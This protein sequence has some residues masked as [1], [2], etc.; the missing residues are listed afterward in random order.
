VAIENFIEPNFR[1]LIGY[2]LLMRWGC[3]MYFRGSERK[4]LPV[5]ALQGN[6][7]TAG[8]ADDQGPTDRNERFGKRLVWLVMLMPLVV[9]LLLPWALGDPIEV[10]DTVRWL[11]IVPAVGAVILFIWS[12]HVDS[13]FAE[14]LTFAEQL[15][16]R[17]KVPP[18]R[19]ARHPVELSDA[20]LFFALA[21]ISGRSIVGICALGAILLQQVIVIPLQDAELKRIL[22]T[23]YDNYAKSGGRFLPK[24]PMLKEARY[25]VPKRFG[26]TA[27]MALLTA[28]SLVFGGLNLLQYFIGVP[29]EFYFFAA[30]QIL[31]VCVAQMVFGSAP[32]MVSAFVGAALLP[33]FL[34]IHLAISDAKLHRYAFS[35]ILILSTF[36]G[37]LIG[38]C[39][40]AV[41]AGFFLFADWFENWFSKSK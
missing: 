30:A 29:R 14:P 10:P 32:R 11:F 5:V 37:G 40:G 41:A 38:Y 2:L 35:M 16:E 17:S 1:I 19:I 24:L 22:G 7:A 36:L 4:L 18:Y 8:M 6:L 27:I 28:L 13:S 9:Y 39:I 20:V 26:M 3:W 15:I 23:D 12:K 25:Q 33:T 31:A 34:A 21:A